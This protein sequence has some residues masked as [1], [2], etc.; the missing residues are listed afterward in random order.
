MNS[1]AFIY[2]SML[3]RSGKESDSNS[4]GYGFDS[5]PLQIRQVRVN[6]YV[7]KLSSVTYQFMVVLFKICSNEIK[8]RWQSD[9]TTVLCR[10]MPRLRNQSMSLDVAGIVSHT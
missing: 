2:V 7:S 10:R 9:L 3:G 1:L 5:L 8:L 4:Q 6:A